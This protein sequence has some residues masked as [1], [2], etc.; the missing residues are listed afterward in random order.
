MQIMQRKHWIF[1]MDGTL[2]QALHDFDAI[3]NELDLPMDMGILEALE[4][5][6]EPQRTQ[7][8]ERLNLIEEALTAQTIIAPGVAEFVG[9]LHQNGCRLGILT[10]NSHNN[11][12][13]T[14]ENIGLDNFF[15]A[16]QVIAREQATPKPSPQGILILLNLWQTGA[17]D[18]VMVGD[19]RDDF[20]AGKNAGVHTL[21]VD[22]QN[23][24]LWNEH[25]HQRVGDLSE[26]LR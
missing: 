26:L 5:L 13:L 2:T 24:Q 15:A 6:P 9:H 1:D 19:F 21:Y 25:C 8:K 22:Y 16:D 11:A 14:L 7:K 18:A 23:D 20:I 12:L 3:R 10:R 17:H 4:K